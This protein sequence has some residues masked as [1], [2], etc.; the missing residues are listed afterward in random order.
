MVSGWQVPASRVRPVDT[1]PEHDANRTVR[2]IVD[3]EQW[4]RPVVVHDEEA[5]LRAY[6]SALSEQ[7]AIDPEQPPPC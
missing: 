6:T 2:M 7:A 5:I 3:A 1:D 4:L